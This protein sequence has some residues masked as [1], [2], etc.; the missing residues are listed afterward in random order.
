MNKEL[1]DLGNYLFNE[2]KQNHVNF[3]CDY[4]LEAE[5]DK[6]LNNLKSVKQ[7]LQ[8]LEA[9]DN[10]KPSEALGCL[11]DFI[12]DNKNS[13]EVSKANNYKTDYLEIKKRKLDIIKQALIKAQE[14]EK[15]IVE[16]CEYCGMDNLY[17]YDNL[18]EIEITFK[19]TFDNY[20]RQRIESLGRL[21][22]QEKALSIIKEKP[23]ECAPTINYIKINKGN[24]KMLNYEHYCMAVKDKVNE[25]EFDLLKRWLG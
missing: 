6:Q 1:D 17:P 3:G 22:K 23:Y 16:L 2:W 25:N 9:I 7:T 15:V 21:N 18:N 8:R 12:E 10:A 20:Q 14:Q 4:K 24:P 5:L 11:N 13:I 19:D